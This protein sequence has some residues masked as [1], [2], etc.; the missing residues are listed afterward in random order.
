MII[1]RGK[2]TVWDGPPRKP[3]PRKTLKD[4]TGGKVLGVRPLPSKVA[5]NRYGGSGWD[6]S[7]VVRR[8]K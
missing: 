8:A 2:R 1:K 7:K 5:E 4:Q 6:P 3:V